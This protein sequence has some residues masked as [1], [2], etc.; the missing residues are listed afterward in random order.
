MHVQEKKDETHREMNS[1]KVKGTEK[2][3]SVFWVKVPSPYF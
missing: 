1:C 2:S 3:L